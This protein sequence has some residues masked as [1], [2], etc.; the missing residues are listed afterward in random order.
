MTN[1]WVDKIKEWGQDSVDNKPL[2]LHTFGRNQL[3]ESVIESFKPKE[4]TRELELGA[5]PTSKCVAIPLSGGLDSV[6]AYEMG[7]DAGHEMRPYYVKLRTP[8]AALELRAL[9]TLGY[10]VTLIDHSDWPARWEPYK[11]RWQH[12]LPG[13]N[14]LIIMS[15]AEAVSDRPV[16]IWL[17]ATEGE[18][19]LTGGDKSVRFFS[20]TGRVLASLPVVHALRFPLKEMTKSDL[21]EWWINSGRDPADL[22]KTVTCQGGTDAPCG[23][24]HACFNRWIALRNNA[25]SETMLADPR[26][27]KS[28]AEK[29]AQFEAA[30]ASR[31]FDTWSE[32]RIMQTLSA[33]YAEE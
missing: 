31:S 16:E 13:R 15:V 8:Y 20:A 21:V 29:V 27:V 19:P 28:N 10:D 18:I 26:T 23:A 12:I 7:K 9:N 33:W 30:L 11:T 25:I 32:R 4:N 14:L 22:L 6:V 2:M 1:S 24:C 3:F 17:G 5:F